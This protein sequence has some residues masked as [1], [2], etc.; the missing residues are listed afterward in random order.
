MAALKVDCY[1]LVSIHKSVS[2]GMLS[3]CL[4]ILDHL[5]REVEL[6][7]FETIL[8]KGLTAIL[9][10]QMQFTSILKIFKIIENLEI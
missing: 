9:K 10:L 5:S 7:T 1:S 3:E 8:N 2:W 6:R 4:M